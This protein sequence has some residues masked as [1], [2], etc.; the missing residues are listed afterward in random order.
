MSRLSKVSRSYALLPSLA[1][2]GT[3]V[4]LGCSG[5]ASPRSSAT[6]DGG[7]IDCGIPRA[8]NPPPCPPTYFPPPSPNVCSPIGFTCAYP[9]A[10]DGQDVNGCGGATAMYWC[11][12]DNG[13]GGADA[14]T[15]HWIGAQ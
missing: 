4:L 5:S 9:G 6:P 14:T 12:A 7:A 10:G 13:D 2:A 15:G 1:V 11:V 3:L 8:K